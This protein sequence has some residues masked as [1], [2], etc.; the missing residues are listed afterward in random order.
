MACGNW[1]SV[2]SASGRSPTG[3]DSVAAHLERVPRLA[4]LWIDRDVGLLRWAP[5]AAL[6]FVAIWLLVRSRRVVV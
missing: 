6:C 2:A 3:A 4:A 1:T 5:F